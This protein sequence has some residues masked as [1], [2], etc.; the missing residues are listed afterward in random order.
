MDASRGPESRANGN[1]TRQRQACSRWVVTLSA[2]LRPWTNGGSAR[3]PVVRG[4]RCVFGVDDARVAPS[5]LCAVERL[6]GEAEELFYC[7]GLGS[8]ANA[9]GDRHLSDVPEWCAFG[10]FAQSAGGGVGRV[11]VGFGHQPGEF[12]TTGPGHE[13]AF[14]AVRVQKLG[15]PNEYAVP[16]W[17][18][19]QVID[20]LEVIEVDEREAEVALVA[21]GAGDLGA[22]TLV[23]GAAVG[24]T[25]QR[26]G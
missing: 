18:T 15:E 9:D 13:F 7:L 26:I 24:D 2:R 16:G 4:S 20:G 21:L 1:T 25:G 8:G 23:E 22:E 3:G 11:V 19:V 12:L 14:A 17:V 10:R 5:L 6:V